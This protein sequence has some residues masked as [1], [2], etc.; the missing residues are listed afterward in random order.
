M[1]DADEFEGSGRI[2]P[3]TKAMQESAARKLFLPS[4]DDNRLREA[5]RLVGQIKATAALLAGFAYSQLRPPPSPAD[6]QLATLYMALDAAT[7]ACELVAV[8]VAQQL[9]SSAAGRQPS[10][11]PHGSPPG[12]PGTGRWAACGPTHRGAAPPPPTTHS[13]GGSSSAARPGRGR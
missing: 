12:P 9:L 2:V 13:T 6:E 3:T 4:T 5:A 10:S 1:D 7:V 8:F 11:C